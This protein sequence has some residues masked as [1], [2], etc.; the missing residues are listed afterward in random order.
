MICLLGYFLSQTLIDIFDIFDCPIK[1]KEES[2]FRIITIGDC[3][4]DGFC[5][6]DTLLS[7]YPS[8][9]Q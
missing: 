3:I 7:S 8:L 1:E 4:T 2:T 5:S 6:S 9:L